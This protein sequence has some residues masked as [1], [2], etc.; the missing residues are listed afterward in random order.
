MK[1]NPR[2]ICRIADSRNQVQKISRIFDLAKFKLEKIN[3]IKVGRNHSNPQK[4]MS[5]ESDF[6][7][8]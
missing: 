1:L 2:E 4:K 6:N 8:F 5:Y 7:P 3:S